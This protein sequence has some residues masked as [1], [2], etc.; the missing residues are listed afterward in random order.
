MHPAHLIRRSIR[1]KLL[2]TMIGLLVVVVA[3]MTYSQISSQQEILRDDLERRIPLLKNHLIDRAKTQSDTLA[4]LAENDI[5]SLNFSHLTSEVNAAV[6]SSEEL[7]YVILMDA[8][9]TAHIHTLYPDLEQEKLTGP[10]D[11]HASLQTKMTAREIQMAGEQVLEF[12]M[13]LKI[14]VQQWGCMRLGFSLDSLQQEITR[15]TQEM[16]RRNRRMVARSLITG[17]A[18]VACGAAVVLW[19]AVRL[20]RPLTLLTE[21]ARQLAKGNFSAARPLAITSQD[22]VGELAAAFS[23]MSEDLK[24]SYHKLEEHSNTL[25]RRVAERTQALEQQTA[26]VQLLQTVAVAANEAS[27]VKEA[28]QTAL[29][30]VCAHTGWPAGHA[31]VVTPPENVLTSS[32]VWHL[33]PPERFAAFRRVRESATFPSGVGLPGRVLASGRPAWIIDVAKDIDLP[34]AGA[35]GEVGLR[36]G[37][38]FPVLVGREVAAVLEFF[39][40]QPTEPSQ[41]LLDLMAHIGTQLGR[42]IERSRAEEAVRQAKEAAEEANQAKSQFLASMSHE[43]RTPLNAII[44]YGEMLQE[45]V[46][47]LGVRELKPDLEKIVAAAR[48]QLSLVND[49]LD[50]SKIE[51]GKMSVFVEEFDLAKLVNEVAATI[52]PLVVKKTNRFVL[53]CPP[54]IGA[55]RTDQTKLRQ[56]L[57]NLL[58]NACKFTENGVI[59]LRV[60]RG[61]GIEGGAAQ[62]PTDL[63]TLDPRRSSFHFTIT[64][65]GIGMT[66]EQLAKL[67]NA[68]TQAD[69]STSKKYGGTGLGLALSRK[70]CELMG[71]TITVDSE[72][73]KGSTFTVILPATCVEAASR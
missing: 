52:Q 64:D 42:V 56:T 58:S 27:S 35:A 70:F 22:E 15:S 67:F 20:S 23:Q 38:A 36:G 71:G 10:E 11:R 41:R 44:G 19:I 50:L 53:D 37:F 26:N 66:P 59:T 8:A 49:I 17:L 29:D 69:A 28:I 43:L 6:K 72:A 32:G 31:Y 54:D 57:F 34:R 16:S 1:W 68:F 24:I 33:D 62:T 30:R 51:A 48:H 61:P 46:D 40:N 7:R 12:V 45:E 55:M 2:A 4:R 73:G 18:F 65:T 21:S 25:E 5:A 60:S 3:L 9:R 14:G 47:D 63:S 13:P 39:S